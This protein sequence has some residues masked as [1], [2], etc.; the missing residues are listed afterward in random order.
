MEEDR[1]L[2]WMVSCLGSLMY[3]GVY[4]KALAWVPFFSH[5]MLVGCFKKSNITSQKLCVILNMQTIHSCIYHFHQLQQ[6]KTIPGTARGCNL[7]LIIA[8]SILNS[9]PTS[10]CAKTMWFV[11]VKILIF[12]LWRFG[13]AL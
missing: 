6:M 5:Y 9:Q 12:M 10:T 11:K 4:P 1:G 2:K 13:K 8:Q 3:S 7:H